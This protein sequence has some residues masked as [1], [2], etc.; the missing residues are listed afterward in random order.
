MVV[1]KI[2]ILISRTRPLAQAPAAIGIALVLCVCGCSD[3]ES[4]GSAENVDPGQL[5]GVL[6]DADAVLPG[7]EHVVP[8][9]AA[10]K[11]GWETEVFSDAASAQL[12]ALFK[13]VESG[14]VTVD[15]LEPL[16]AKGLR[17]VD[18][19]PMQL[20]DSFQGD[21]FS[22]R[23]AAKATLDASAITPTDAGSLAKKLTSL[24]APFPGATEL[25]SKIKVVDVQL[26]DA[27]SVSRI[28]AYIHLG[29]RHDRGN[30]QIKATWQ[31]T[32]ERA[33]SDAPPRLA[34]IR[35]DDYEEIEGL[36]ATG[37]M[38]ADCTDAV[39][40]HNSIFDQQLRPGIDH[41]LGRIDIRFG[42]DIGGWQGISVADV[43]GDG[44]DDLYVSQPGGLPNR[45]FVQR[46]DG[47][48]DEVSAKAGVDFIDSAH[49]STFVDLD[50]D[51]DQDLLAGV[52]QGIVVCENDGTGTFTSKVHLALP[53]A[54]PYSIA[55]ADYDRDGDL[56]F[57]V[58]CYNRRRHTRTNT[59]LVFARPVPYHDANNGG[60]N[61]LFRNDG[62][63]RFRHVTKA[64]GLDENNRRFSYAAAWEDYD[65][66]GDLDLYVANDFGRNNLYRNDRGR[67]VDVAKD[68]GVEDI[69]PGMSACWGDY[70]NDGL[71][72]LYISNMFSSAGN[73]IT[74]Q[75]G[76]HAGTDEATLSEFRRHARGN[77]LFRNVGG[78]KFED[79]SETAQVVIGRW[80]WG[81]RFVDLNNDGW[82]D[83]LVTNG[84]ITQGKADDL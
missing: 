31:T 52:E 47:S 28:G 46:S 57:F 20:D 59:H 22:V 42:L 2:R 27:S 35:V 78:G 75:A 62:S 81:S 5:A 74:T 8:K 43:N 67:F 54:I 58:C 7:T 50:N 39:L 30:F 61:V 48:A 66:D 36:S 49:G 82:Q 77:S 4:G 23:R 69:S 38:F 16:I 51:G 37:P 73:R 68:A 84:F 13:L 15:S 83:L 60:R 14:K 29:G 6:P 12:K 33:S 40:A 1:R 56:D 24:L 76:F 32:W 25:H 3:D 10:D 26:G 63:W 17:S 34:S 55:A 53:A 45:L 18:L 70:D 72:D 79:V 64:V 71:P 21:A 11:D 80:A 9:D 19:R 65:N 44:L 41:W